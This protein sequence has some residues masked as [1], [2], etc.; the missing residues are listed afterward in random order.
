MGRHPF[1]DIGCDLKHL[2]RRTNAFARA[3]A[4]CH[5]EGF[6]SIGR[7]VVF[8]EQ[9]DKASLRDSARNQCLYGFNH[10]VHC[11]SIPWYGRKASEAKCLQSVFRTAEFNL[12]HPFP[13][14]GLYDKS[15]DFL[16][17]V[18]AKTF[19][20]MVICRERRFEIP[21]FLL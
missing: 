2:T 12:C 1:V 14:H 7:V 9:L 13:V 17:V 20:H 21:E 5:D 19:D 11:C 16:R 10:R 3:L 15:L 18:I 6:Q 4:K 8:R